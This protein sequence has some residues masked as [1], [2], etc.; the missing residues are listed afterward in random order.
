MDAGGQGLVIK[1]RELKG[2]REAVLKL[3]KKGNGPEG[4]ERFVQ[5]I[6]I[7]QSIEH[8]NI[9]RLLADGRDAI[10]PWYITPLGV[11]FDKYWLERRAELSPEDLF[12]E[13]RQVILALLSGLACF[14]GAGGVHRDIKPGNVLI[15]NVG[16]SNEPVLIDFG[17]AFRRA[18]PSIT[19]ENK[20][21]RPNAF[22]GPVEA[23]YGY[24][25]DPP[26]AWDCYS[27]AC[28]W[29]WMLAKDPRVAFGH[30]HWKH[31]MCTAKY[32][33]V[34]VPRSLVG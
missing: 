29:S 5:D 11:P 13:A 4:T 20:L 17:F 2:A 30:Y 8:R 6:K 10:P 15:L 18:F 14:H 12:T 3:L 33:S 16:G 31:R 27:M 21:V 25:D 28:L 23:Y 34:A 1:I 22:G 19:P 7:L 32:R 9:V 26:A 24:G